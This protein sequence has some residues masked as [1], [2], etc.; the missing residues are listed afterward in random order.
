MYK[1]Q[2][3]FLPSCFLC[4]VHCVLCLP[5]L[6]MHSR[7]VYNHSEIVLCLYATKAQWITA[8]RQETP[9]RRVL[10][11]SFILTSPIH[12][13]VAHSQ[14]WLA[15]SSILLFLLPAWRN[16]FSEWKTSLDVS[17]I[18]I[19]AGE[20]AYFALK[21]EKGWKK[22]WISKYSGM[23]SVN[24]RHYGPALFMKL[25]LSSLALLSIS[26]MK[27]PPALN[28]IHRKVRSH[29]HIRKNFR[30]LSLIITIQA[31]LM[32]NIAN[33]HGKKRTNLRTIGL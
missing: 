8:R 1:E 30:P 10:N 19:S 13:L 23:S 2:L 22:K 5:F 7:H 32:N 3:F 31:S 16:P 20:K 11:D 28:N 14:T 18:Y 24:I 9:L 33:T 26:H 27:H 4:L 12:S 21:E 25:P 17:E 29:F 6:I 15:I